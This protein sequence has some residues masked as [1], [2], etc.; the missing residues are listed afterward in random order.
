MS[1]VG[2]QPKDL[3]SRG[4]SAGFKV[5][6]SHLSG[7]AGFVRVLNTQDSPC[8]VLRT[9]PLFVSSPLHLPSASCSFLLFKKIYIRII[10]CFLLRVHPHL[11]RNIFCTSLPPGAMLWSWALPSLLCP[12]FVGL[13]KAVKLGLK[14]ADS[15]EG[16]HGGEALAGSYGMIA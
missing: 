3:H 5:T 11:T 7:E 13:E 2:F 4:I 1:E 12:L 6:P 10:R 14:N 15:K 16:S 8:S 9:F